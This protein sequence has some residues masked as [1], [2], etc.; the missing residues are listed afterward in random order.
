MYQK[1]DQHW[2]KVLPLPPSRPN[3]FS[4]TCGVR[5]RQGRYKHVQ[6][7][8]VLCRMDLFA[9]ICCK[10]MEWA[11]IFNLHI[12]YPSAKGMNNSHHKTSHLP[13]HFA[14]GVSSS[15]YGT[16]RCKLRKAVSWHDLRL[17]DRRDTPLRMGLLSQGDLFSQKTSR[18]LR[19][20]SSWAQLGYFPDVG[21]WC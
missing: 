14:T 7:V 11:E 5:W 20:C 8:I 12:R 1:W 17:G 13:G 6:A 16:H 4:K 21:L 19:C 3:N 9:F 2:L 18:L 10:Q 15:M